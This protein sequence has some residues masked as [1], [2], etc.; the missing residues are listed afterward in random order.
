MLIFKILTR[1]QWTS[2]CV[3]GETKGA[4]IDL[5]DGFIHFSTAA[6]TAETAAKH[7]AGADD[8]ILLA[9]ESEPLGDTLKWEVSRNDDQFPHLY[10]TL[11]LADITWARD[12]PLGDHGHILP[13]GVE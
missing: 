8:L 12:M 11:R 13:D 10:R 9:V 6:Q 5:S 7:F 2:L 4:P 3:A 1:P